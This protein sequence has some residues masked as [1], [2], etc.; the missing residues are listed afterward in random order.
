MSDTL[1]TIV[2]DK[3]RHVAACKARRPQAAVEAA[4]KTA[5][6]AVARSTAD[7]VDPAVSRF[8]DGAWME[9][10]L[11]PNTLAAYRARRSNSCV[12]TPARQSTRTRTGS[13]SSMACP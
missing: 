12:C 1:A 5:S 6:N 2:D 10:G 11:S 8:L 4:A 3:R 7:V 13:A 9:R